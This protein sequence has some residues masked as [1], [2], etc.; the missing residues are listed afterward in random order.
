MPLKKSKKSN[1]FCLEGEWNDNL[2]HK[3]SILPALEL[4][5]LNNGIKTIY[6]TFATKEEFNQR[7]STVLINKPINRGFD[8]IYLA[9]HGS[10]NKIHLED[11]SYTLETLAEKF[12]NKLEHKII[13]FGSCK[14]LSISK[15][16][17]QFFLDKTKALAI[18][19]YQ[20]NIKFISSTV[21]DV[22]YFEICQHFKDIKAI[23]SNMENYCGDLV[24]A[25]KF[26]IYYKKP[27]VSKMEE[28]KSQHVNAYEKWSRTDDLLLTELYKKKISIAKLAQQFGRN[29]GAIQSRLKKLMDL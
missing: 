27:A 2:K 25:L 3:S 4:L 13:H 24:N 5:E 1:I 22:L 12:E 28:T 29:K 15:E 19:G 6:R 18:S 14:T 11:D 20:S 21:V 8:I 17:A 7:V 10:T 26:K 16:R 23:E 9:F